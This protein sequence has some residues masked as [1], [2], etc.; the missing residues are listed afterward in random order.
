MPKYTEDR[1][2]G[3]YLY[4]TSKC[5]VEA[6]HVHADKDLRHERAAKFWVG[7]GGKTKVTKRGRLSDKSI[8]DI[9]LYIKNNYVD[10]YAR[11]REFSDQGFY[12]G[13]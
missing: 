9:Q 13:V 5:T 1:I 11:W 3:Y 12:T 8:R 4:F 6:M 7:A 2:D 10:M